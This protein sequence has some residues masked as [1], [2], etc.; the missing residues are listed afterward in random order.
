VGTGASGTIEARPGQAY[1]NIV[2][3]AYQRA[4]DGQLLVS[5][6]GL[7]MPTSSQK[8]LGNITPDWIGGL[9]NTFSFKGFSLNILLDF[10]QGNEIISETKYR[11]EASGDGAWTT[12]GRRVK[13]KDAQGNQL[14]LVGV[15][16][17]V[18]AVDDGS[19]NITYQP[20]TKAVY[21]QDYWANR[22]WSDITE[23]FVMD[24]SYISLREVMLSYNFK[25]S[26]LK[27]TPF[28]GIT[29]SVLGRNLMYL[30]QHMQGMGVSPESA[31]NTSAG[32][33]G[34]ESFAIPTTR[35]WGFNVKLIF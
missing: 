33:A 30:E 27:K 26:I 16:P 17:G 18:V 35:T 24:G 2:G 6:G 19:G 15:L 14:P 13:D 3:Y 10:V 12:E 29:L 5:D 23:E 20:N 8:I 21:G 1:G 9:N 31:P 7:Y 4:P 11:C 25:S 34:S 32:Y 28:A 22:A